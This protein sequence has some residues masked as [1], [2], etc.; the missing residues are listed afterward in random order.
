MLDITLHI[1]DR[2]GMTHEVQA[3]NRYGYECHGSCERF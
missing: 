3:P 1:T 2:D